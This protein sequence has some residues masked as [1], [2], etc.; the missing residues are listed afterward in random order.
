MNCKFGFI[1]LAVAALFVATPSCTV[2]EQNDSGTS[3]ISI[4]ISQAAKSSTN[5][6]ISWIDDKGDN[7]NYTVKVYTNA[8][9]TDLYQQYE[10]KFREQEDKR[11]TIPYLDATRKYYICVEN[12]SGYKSNPFEVQLETKHVRGEVVSQNFDKLFWGYDYIN[13]ANGVVLSDDINPRNYN[14]SSFAEFM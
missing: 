4:R 6:T 14:I 8:D 3:K 1:A 10:L 7:I 12:I 2:N 5:T 9:C 11:F 13:S